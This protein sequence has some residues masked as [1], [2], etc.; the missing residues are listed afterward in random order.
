ME[1]GLLLALC[2]QSKTSLQQ[3]IN[4]FHYK[5]RRFQLQSSYLNHLFALLRKDIAKAMLIKPAD[6][7]N[8]EYDSH[9]LLRKLTETQHQLAKAACIVEKADASLHRDPINPGQDWGQFSA[10]EVFED[11]IATIGE[12]IRPASSIHLKASHNWSD[13][14]PRIYTDRLLLNYVLY[15]AVGNLFNTLDNQYKSVIDLNMHFERD[16]QL[17]F[18]TLNIQQQPHTSENSRQQSPIWRSDLG[19][20]EENFSHCIE[21][22]Q[23]LLQNLNGKLNLKRPSFMEKI[24]EIELPIVN[25]IPQLLAPRHDQRISRN[26]LAQAAQLADHASKYEPNPIADSSQYIKALLLGETQSSYITLKTCLEQAS[27]ELI[28]VA[29]LVELESLIKANSIK[30]ILIHY[31]YDN[32]TVEK[33]LHKLRSSIADVNI[34]IIVMTTDRNINNQLRL[35]PMQ[36]DDFILLPL[37]ADELLIRVSSSLKRLKTIWQAHQLM[38]QRNLAED[39]QKILLSP[40]NQLPGIHIE[41]RYLAADT[42]SGDWYQTFYDRRHHRLFAIV[43]DVAGRGRRAA[44]IATTANGAFRALTQSMS[45][46]VQALSLDRCLWDL[47]EGV[48]QAIYEAANHS[49]R[50]MTVTF[51]ALDLNSG[52]LLYS[53]AGG[54]PIYITN[55]HQCESVLIGGRPLGL[56]KQISLNY[57]RMHLSP[58]SAI[59]LST[60][61]LLRNQGPD[62]QSLSQRQLIQL[63][64]KAGHEKS[65]QIADSILLEAKSIW[66]DH[67][68]ADDV[69]VLVIYWF[70]ATNPLFLD[71]ESA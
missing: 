22:C 40:T 53:N 31:E 11:A 55:D 14:G 70:H 32:Q 26:I 62:G 2:W 56:T 42:T 37:S 50:T 6:S 17:F 10:Q 34:A 33:I 41:G 39:F 54:G 4:I 29:D 47:I 61:G 49:Q 3:V 23:R 19:Q 68:L 58:H 7:S 35:I 43:G 13:H 18:V 52:D 65:Q 64:T 27:I 44:L 21:F 28:W 60:D 9:H 38:E 1:H 71:E 25:R 57:R 67:A 20:A 46:K 24:I 15:E 36:L 48:N 30:L 63:L 8:V 59:F 16:H 12:L 66:K 69:V 45:K 51:I 5:K